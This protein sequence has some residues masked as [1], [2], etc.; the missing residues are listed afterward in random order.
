M[1]PDD[2]QRLNA[3]P[4]TLIVDDDP[5]LLDALTEYLRARGN[6][7]ESTCSFE[8]AERRLRK[9][10]F[11]LLITD[12][13]ITGAG[14][15]EGLELLQQVRQQHSNTRVLLL[16]GFAT[17]EIEMEARFRGVDMVLRK[18]LPLQAL[19]DIAAGLIASSRSAHQELKDR[20]PALPAQGSTRT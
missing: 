2:Q 3:C 18:P 8:D 15:A 10:N 14:G 20:Q 11:A 1:Q 7:V 9:T 5:V 4:L 16:T 17:P 19:A 12:L 13:K 6:A